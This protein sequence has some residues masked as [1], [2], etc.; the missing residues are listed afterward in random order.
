MI[1]VLRKCIKQEILHCNSPEFST[2]YIR[3]SEKENETRTRLTNPINIS[4]Y[5]SITFL[6]IRT[7]TK[8]KECGYQVE[9]TT[10]EITLSA[11]SL[12][13]FKLICF[14]NSISTDFHASSSSKCVVES[15][16]NALLIWDIIWN[17]KVGCTLTTGLSS[18]GSSRWCNV[19]LHFSTVNSMSL[20]L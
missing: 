5:Y 8:S 11:S 1:K 7:T 15:S 20:C 6:S 14:L 2:V 10:S 4:L 3:H 13:S 19:C 16:V 9:Y 17:S 18:S 12:F